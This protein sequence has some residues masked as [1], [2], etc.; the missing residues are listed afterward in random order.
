MKA[1]LTLEKVLSSICFL[2]VAAFFVAAISGVWRYFI[3][4]GLSI[5]IGLMISTDHDPDEK[6]ER[7][8][9]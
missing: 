1:R 5:A 4:M 3:T 6:E 8:K 9:P 7:H 2:T